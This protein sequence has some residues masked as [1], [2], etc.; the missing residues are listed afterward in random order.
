MS[1]AGRSLVVSSDGT[2]PW[3][4]TG[5]RAGHFGARVALGTPA[6]GASGIDADLGADGTLAVAWVAGGAAH[7][8]V[9]PPSGSPRP[10]IDLPA[11]GTNGVAVAVAPDA[12]I[13][14]AYRTKVGKTYGVDV[15]TAPPGGGFGA[16]TTLDSGTAGI[17]SPTSPRGPAA[18]SRSP[19]ARS[20]P[21]T[22]RAS[23][24]APQA[25]RRS[26]RRRACP[27]GIRP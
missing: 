18:R 22:A 20:S 6:D 3:L 17:D 12:S 11:V 14:L 26:T 8:T 13:T 19:T 23:R 9:V 10:Q 2:A 15:V 24:S 5:D 27:A 1:A 25:P 7:V 16:P 4:A 21:S